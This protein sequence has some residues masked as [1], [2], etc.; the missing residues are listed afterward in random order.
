MTTLMTTF[1]LTLLM[2]ISIV[3]GMSYLRY[4]NTLPHK[5]EADTKSFEN[6]EG[7]YHNSSFYNVAPA[8]FTGYQYI[9]AGTW[10]FETKF[11]PSNATASGT[12]HLDSSEYYTLFSKQNGANTYKNEVIDDG[13]VGFLG[14]GD[15]STGTTTTT[16][17]STIG[18]HATIRAVNVASWNDKADISYTTESSSTPTTLFSK[19]NYGDVTGYT[20]VSAGI[21]YFSYEL[22]NK[23]RGME[24][25]DNWS[26]VLFQE[27][28]YTVWLTSAGPFVSA[29]A[30]WYKKR[31]VNEVRRKRVVQRLAVSEQNSV[32][33][34][35]S[36]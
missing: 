6:G 14:N 32:Q 25:P 34:S 27:R 3:N 16:G 7:Y 30:V 2:M 29:D 15:T 11:T 17:G 5:G 24:Q 20:N 1:T 31:S 22:D 4:A 10:T 36:N 33:M 35:E 23:K 28:R 26:I 9:E 13:P 18:D 8:T 21:Y 19:V 12:K